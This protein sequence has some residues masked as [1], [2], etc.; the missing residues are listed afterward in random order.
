MPGQY[1]TMQFVTG[2]R[3]DALTV[4][5]QA[6]TRMGGKATVWMV[7]DGMTPAQVLLRWQSIT[8]LCTDLGWTHD[9]TTGPKPLQ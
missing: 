6:V 7:K 5:V 2:E 8:P 1:V 9:G 4:P 3:P